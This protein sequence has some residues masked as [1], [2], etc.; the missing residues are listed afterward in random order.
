MGSEDLFINWLF[1][2]SDFPTGR[3]FPWPWP[4]PQGCR[5]NPPERGRSR[6]QWRHG[7][8]N[9]LSF[10]CVLSLV[11]SIY[12][13]LCIEMWWNDS[14][15]GLCSVKITT[16]LGGALFLFFPLP[17]GFFSPIILSQWSQQASKQA[18][19]WA[20]EQGSKRPSKHARRQAGQ[21]AR[22]AKP[23][24][25]ANQQAS[26]PA[27]KQRGKG[28]SKQASHAR[29]PEQEPLCMQASKPA[30]QQASN[31]GSKQGS[32]PASQPASQPAS[33]PA[34]IS[35]VWANRR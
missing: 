4:C 8:A 11:H 5:R 23:A 28:A 21:P 29:K 19:N 10:M 15:G 2:D 9:S 30:R 17:R 3:G 22:P 1:G 13:Y 6:S 34:T 31:W 33:K 14:K 7:G 27:S 26:K 32:K 16:I 12:L 18:S 24:E 25:P 20:T 35:K